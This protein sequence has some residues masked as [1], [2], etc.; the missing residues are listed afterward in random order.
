MMLT[1]EPSASNRIQSC[2]VLISHLDAEHT[3]ELRC[4][5]ECYAHDFVQ[6]KV[7]KGRILVE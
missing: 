3:V 5:R 2:G 6:A 1:D 4:Y 7:R